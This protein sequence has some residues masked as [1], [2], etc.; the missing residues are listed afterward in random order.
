MTDE[1]VLALAK[2]A[3]LDK[4]LSVALHARERMDERRVSWADV[5][6]AVA[7]AV[8]AEPRTDED[9]RKSW[10]LTGRDTDGADLTVAVSVGL[11]GKIR[12][13]SVF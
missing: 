5:R 9:G 1:E 12:L 11:D 3:A 6:M 2:R 4:T 8:R 10:R 13:V 7:T